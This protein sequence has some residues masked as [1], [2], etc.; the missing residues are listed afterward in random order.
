VLRG[1]AAALTAARDRAAIIH[2]GRNIAAAGHE[3]EEE[4]RAVLRRRLA[5]RYAV[6]RG[7]VVDSRWNQSPDF[8]VLISDTT[9]APVL[10]EAARGQ[11]YVPFEAVYAVGEVKSGFFGTGD[12]EKF[13][14]DL[15][16]LNSSLQR[17][18][19][20][21]N[22][23]GHGITIQG[24]IADDKRPYRNP[25][26]SFMV[27]V[28]SDGYDRD[29]LAGFYAS[30]PVDEL[31][32][33]VTFLDRGSVARAK[34]RLTDDGPVEPQWQVNPAVERLAAGEG[35]I[36]AM[37]P[38][39]DPGKVLGFLL[40]LLAQHLSHCYLKAP[41]YQAYTKDFIPTGAADVISPLTKG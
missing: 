22:Y 26:F 13:A 7:H 34:V 9:Y 15:R 19:T 16:S 6:G 4:V 5:Q 10:F 33:I 27:F 20:P 31:P 24:A 2:R 32:S 1:D 21:N 40:L 25:L 28:N 3:I 11:Q 12:F 41:N 23:L 37:V 36:W 39:A 30:R 8:D 17:E 29:Q 18:R 38:V 14:D 35:A